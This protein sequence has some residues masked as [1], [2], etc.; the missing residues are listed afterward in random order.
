MLKAGW[1]VTYEQSGAEYGKWGKEYFLA[2]EEQ[3][4]C[5]FSFA[6]LCYRVLH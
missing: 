6:C 3:A 1:A 2:L 5:V 4:K